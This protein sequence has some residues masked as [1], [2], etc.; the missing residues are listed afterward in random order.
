MSF[1]GNAANL[2]FLLPGNGQSV[3][4]EAGWGKSAF[5]PSAKALRQIYQRLQPEGYL[6]LQ[7]NNSWGLGSLYN[8]FLRRAGF[9]D[10]ESYLTLPS[11][12]NCK[13]LVPQDNP[14]AF[15]YCL[16]E[17]IGARMFAATR[18]TRSLFFLIKLLIKLSLSGVLMRLAP[19]FVIIAKKGRP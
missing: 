14:F 6:C 4:L 19:D 16:S 8:L 9:T 15:Q 13:Y 11:A 10:L 17:L 7:A 12:R 1:N 18:L 3:I 5:F 2:Q